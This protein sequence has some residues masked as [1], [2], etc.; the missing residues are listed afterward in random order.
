M[1][2]DYYDLI[3]I[4]REVSAEEIRRA[5]RKCALLYHPVRLPIKYFLSDTIV[6]G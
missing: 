4:R 1:R 2:Y 5:Y 3:G 6:T